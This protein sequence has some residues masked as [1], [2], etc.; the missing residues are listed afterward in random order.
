MLTRLRVLALMWM[1]SS[2]NCKVDRRLKQEENKEEWREGRPFEANKLFNNIQKKQKQQ[3]EKKKRNENENEI[4]TRKNKHLFIRT[5]SSI[6]SEKQNRIKKK[7]FFFC[8]P[9]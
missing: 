5:I 7:L 8:F 3:Q 1:S 2:R 9:T 6:V 4:K